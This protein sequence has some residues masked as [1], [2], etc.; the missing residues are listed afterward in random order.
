MH[1][2][3]L[4]SDTG[5][6][7][8]SDVPGLGWEA[9]VTYQARSCREKSQELYAEPHPEEAV[10]AGYYSW[11]QVCVGPVGKQQWLGSEPVQ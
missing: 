1:F 8:E 4:W 5:K 9:V 2:P 3:F 10:A 6:C 7:P 11:V